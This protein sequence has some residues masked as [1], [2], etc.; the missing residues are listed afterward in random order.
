MFIEQRL[1]SVYICLTEMKKKKIVAPMITL[2]TY[3]CILS[4]DYSAWK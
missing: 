4:Y 3:I 2:S 1:E